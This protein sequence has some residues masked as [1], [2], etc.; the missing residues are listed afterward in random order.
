MHQV[1]CSDLDWCG[2][3]ADLMIWTIYIAPYKVWL[4]PSTILAPAEANQIN[5]SSTEN[6]CSEPDL[7]SN[8]YKEAFDSR[9]LA[10]KCPLLQFEFQFWN[11]N[12]T[13]V[14][15]ECSKSI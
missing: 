1:G 7:F 13:R 6:I 3:V 8:L 10:T 11:P 9:E 4:P 14:R 2:E 15:L 12:G 5:E